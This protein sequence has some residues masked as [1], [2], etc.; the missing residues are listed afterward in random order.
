MLYNCSHTFLCACWHFQDVNFSSIQFE[1][2][3]RQ[4]ENLNPKNSLSCCFSS[5]RAPNKFTSFSPTFWKVSVLCTV[6]GGLP[7]F[8]RNNRGK[9]IHFNFSRIGRPSMLLENKLYLPFTN[10]SYTLTDAH[11]ESC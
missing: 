5:P 9:S 7:V 1:I 11:R 6:F 8:S 3:R 4:K 2:H 10:S